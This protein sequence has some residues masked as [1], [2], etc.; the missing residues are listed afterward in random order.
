MKTIVVIP[1]YNERENVEAMAKAV[2]ENL[3]AEGVA[4][5]VDDNSPDGTGEL[6]DV[7]A[8]ENLLFA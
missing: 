4:L 7:L 2:L 5:F 8:V 1:T 3:P 6:I